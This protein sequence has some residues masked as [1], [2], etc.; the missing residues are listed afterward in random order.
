MIAFS[1]WTSFYRSTAQLG[2]DFE[3]ASSIATEDAFAQMKSF[4]PEGRKAP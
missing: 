4:D 1:L 3:M 2:W